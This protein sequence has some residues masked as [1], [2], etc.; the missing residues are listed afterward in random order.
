MSHIS[1]CDTSMTKKRVS[2]TMRL[3]PCYVT[4]ICSRHKSMTLILK[5]QSF[6]TFDFYV[7]A[8]YMACMPFSY[9]F[10][11]F[12]RTTQQLHNLDKIPGCKKLYYQTHTR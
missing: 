11:D 1:I 2:K 3:K 7:T 12:H 9:F 5:S 6:M 4:F 10:I 8:S